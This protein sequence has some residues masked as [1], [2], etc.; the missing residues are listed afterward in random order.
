[1]D[2]DHGNIKAA[3]TESI[4][5]FGGISDE[6][7]SRN[8]RVKL[9]DT[10]LTPTSLRVAAATQ[11]LSAGLEEGDVLYQHTDTTTRAVIYNETLLKSSW[12]HRWR[13]GSD[14]VASCLISCCRSLLLA[15]IY[16]A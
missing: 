11:K 6:H 1:M 16:I 7:I 5:W 2:S 12:R 3:H 14:G 4:G 8:N 13:A 10:R 15:N 9:W